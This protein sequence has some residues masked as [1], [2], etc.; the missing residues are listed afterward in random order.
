VRNALSDLGFTEELD[1][2]V[3]AIPKL[4]SGD[5]IGRI[6]RIDRGRCSFWCIS[7]S[8]L[9]S[10]DT[11]TELKIGKPQQD[12]AVGDWIIADR[13]VERVKLVLPRRT[14][15]V[16]RLSPD[17][18]RFRLQTIATN[19]D[20]TFI[21]CSL[22]T[23][24]NPRRLE[25]ELVVAHDSGAIPI[26][27]LTKRDLVSST[28]VGRSVAQVNE[29]AKGIE[30][31]VVSSRLGEGL[32]ELQSRL[33]P[34]VTAVFLGASGTGKS[35]LVNAMVGRVVQNTGPLREADKRGRHT[36]TAVTLLQLPTR[37]M[38]V[39]V[40]GI[41]SVGLAIAGHGIE[42]TFPEIQ[43]LARLC[44]FRDC[45]HGSEPECRVQDAIGLGQI[46]SAR[47][48][49]WKRLVAERTKVANSK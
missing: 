13:H 41:R 49:N 39:D 42:K 23:A 33:L 6:N 22:D 19:I 16:R 28:V 47:F 35:T 1:Q 27:V 17:K 48:S 5:L 20:I 12:I 3:R 30:S 40:P 45:R 9:S 37:G 21:T 26:V 4:D 29:I 46:D 32:T 36:T 7:L 14:S 43:E 25:R 8:R 34:G 44:R 2:N 11:P 31:F 18:S 10:V 38:I 24:V 15:L